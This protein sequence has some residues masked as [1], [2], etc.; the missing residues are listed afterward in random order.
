[1][2]APHVFVIAEAGVNHNGDIGMASALVDAAA[3]AGAD[4][5]KFQTFRADKLASRAAEKA[6]YQKDTTG[7]GESQLE[8]LRRL[9][10][11][12]SWHRQ[13]IERCAARGIAFLS[14][15]FDLE[16]LALLSE[17]LAL[18]RIKLGSGELT[19]A[20]LLHAAGL[21]GAAVI[22]STGMG[23]LE[24]VE[25]ALGALA[26]G[27][28]RVPPGIEAFHAAFDS[29]EGRSALSEKVALL[30]CTTE[31]P[32]PPA[33]INLRAMGA[34]RDAFGLAVGYSDHTT[35][36]A[37]PVAA[38]GRGATIIEKHV[39]LDRGLPGPDHRA[40]LE[41]DELR[42]LVSM[43]RE[44]EQALGDGVKRPMPSEMKNMA[45]ARK[46][47]VTTRPI[48]AGERFTPENLTVKRPGN[49][50]SPFEYW[51]V[52]GTPATRSY[53]ADEAIEP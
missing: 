5:V 42:T 51:S 34:L 50:R 2:P 53:E 35:G 12:I 11:P 39:T 20:P 18:P 9:E 40:S 3:D 49:G 32:A 41:P 16:S 28:L 1:M 27:Y 6:A 29:A 7:G 47:L 43:I 8:M 38:V 25:A 21:T 46:S 19:N 33:D 14:T 52:L 10:M 30:H 4:C 44:V 23:T 22:L 17:E 45:V 31:Y 26:A 13:L 24:E 36:L 15:P 48:A 37:V